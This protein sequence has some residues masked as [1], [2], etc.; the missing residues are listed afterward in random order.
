MI[1]RSRRSGAC[2]VLDRKAILLLDEVQHLPSWASRLKGEW[3][4]ARSSALRLG[5]GSSES[6]AELGSYAGALPLRGDSA[7]FRAYVRDAVVEPVNRA[8]SSRSRPCDDR[9]S[10]AGLRP[11]LR[12]ARA[13]TASAD[14]GRTRPRQRAAES[15]T[16]SPTSLS[17][18]SSST[19]RTRPSRYS[20][21][22]PP[23]PA[24]QTPHR[25][26]GWVGVR[27]SDAIRP[28][29]CRRMPLQGQ[30]NTPLGPRDGPLLLLQDSHCTTTAR[31]ATRARI[32]T[33][34]R[35]GRASCGRAGTA[36]ASRCQA[37]A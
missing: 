7:R 29:Q 9:G 4:R 20:S 31:P 36:R 22:R 34:A 1:S 17:T 6:L 8:T 37:A 10:C 15:V 24:A 32:R 12:A 25:L 14:T 13:T 28:S 19:P 3:D 21:T 33:R 5:A 27:L 11:V 16:R 30:E 2:P 18:S 26:F 35:L 23:E